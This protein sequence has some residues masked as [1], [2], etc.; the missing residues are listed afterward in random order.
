MS[1]A[2]ERDTVVVF[3]RD[4]VP[5]D[6]GYTTL[7][8]AEAPIG[9]VKARVFYGAGSETR[10]MASQEGA[11]QAVTFQVPAS[12]IT[13]QVVVTDKIREDRTGNTWDIEGIAYRNR[14][15]IEFT[16]R[17]AV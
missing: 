12:T 15:N 7:P 5:I 14:R 6:D 4:G 13:R 1:R 17:R 16:A 3:L 2:G 10:L 9:Q 8:G 11:V